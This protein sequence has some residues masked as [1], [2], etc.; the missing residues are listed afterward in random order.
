MRVKGDS[1]RPAK[2]RPL[3]FDLLP[4]ADDVWR[5]ICQISKNITGQ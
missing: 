3:I 2:F 4:Y 1:N 5:H